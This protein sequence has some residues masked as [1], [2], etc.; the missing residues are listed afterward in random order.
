[1]ALNID[2]GGM[3]AMAAVIREQRQVMPRVRSLVTPTIGPDG[4]V[5]RPN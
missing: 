1:M 3:A 4:Q 2:E 5:F